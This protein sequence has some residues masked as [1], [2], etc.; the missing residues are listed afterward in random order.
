MRYLALN[1]DGILIVGSFAIIVL[2]MLADVHIPDRT[3]GLA[4]Y[5]IVLVAG[6]MM[7]AGGLAM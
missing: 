4:F 7:I 3:K 1:V 6:A 2:W 5:L